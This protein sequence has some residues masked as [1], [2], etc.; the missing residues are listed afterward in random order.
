MKKM[1][2]LALAAIV[3]SLVFGNPAGV[4]AQQ[5]AQPATP[6]PATPAPPSATPVTPAAEAVNPLPPEIYEPILR[7]SRSV[8]TAEKAIQQLKELESELQRLRTDVEKIIYES[9][10]E[11]ETLRPKLAEVKGQIEKLGPPQAKDQPPESPTVAAERARLNALAAALDGA[12]KT[13]ELAWVRAK[14][15]ID[16]ITVIR[17]QLFTRNLFERRDSP[18][19]PG[20]WRDSRERFDTVVNRFKYYGGDWLGWAKR[21]SFE[22]T[23]L[24]TGILLLYLGLRIGF[25]ALIRPKLVR[26]EPSPSFFDRIIRAA[27]IV[28]LRMLPAAAAAILAYAGLSGLDLLFPPWDG[29]AL[30]MLKGILVY[31]VSSGLLKVVLAPRH[32]AWRLIPVSDATAFR[33]VFFLEAF[34]A[35]YVLDSI[36]ID[37]GRAVYVPLTL[38]IIQSFLVSV[39]FAG[40][41]VALLVTPFAAQ[42]GPDRPVNGHEYVPKPV[43][44][45][46]PAWIKL[47]L[48]LVAASILITSLL[49]Y[50]ALGRFIAHQ[51]VLSGIVA[52]FAGLLYLAVRAVTRGRA[53]GKDLIGNMIEARIG[54]DGSRRHQ[55]SRLV[56][57]TL[58]LVI[59]LLAIPALLL[60]WGFSSADI[61]DWM[62]AALFG[63]EIGQF[64]ISLFRILLGIALFTGLLF[65]TRVLQRWLRDRVLAQPRVDAGIANSI[66]TAVG[67][68]GSALALLLAVSYAGFDIT[69]LAIVAGAL[70]VGIGFGLQSI[71]NNFVSGL[72]LLVERPIKVGDWIVVGSEQGNV[73]RISVRSTEIETFD[74]ASLII[75]NSELITGRVLNWTHRNQTGRTIIKISVDPDSDPERVMQI[76]RAAVD[77]H[78]DVTKQPPPSISFDS[79]SSQSL[80]FTIRVILDDVYRGGMVA[81]DLRIAILKIL[82]EQGLTYRNPQH[83]VH[84]RDLDAVKTLIQR[85]AAQRAAEAE[86]RPVEP[87]GSNGQPGKV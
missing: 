16:R 56:E 58:T 40:L 25:A 6:P 69:S 26:P 59:G 71:V 9:T 51:L 67:Y 41:L 50:V 87:N 10:A 2:W 74:R 18:A 78:P 12:V 15:L 79:F 60:Q 42:I 19:L 39:L 4:L 63:F 11:A 5:P 35:V 30:T 8:E 52:G 75:P 37:F 22:L 64:R 57:L 43:T 34:V 76:L 47:P 24:V 77:S 81:T 7:L 38:T 80:D 23:A 29:P 83:D 1:Y 85:V 61:R 68:A 84:L 14:Q 54:I 17:Y 3:L 33:L 66:D 13:T 44:F 46:S 72:I 31:T 86:G 70:S 82:R 28:P 53:E 62:K 65:L 21:K 32:P 55:L 49:G 48:W 36:L 73:R 27:W 20:V 45:L